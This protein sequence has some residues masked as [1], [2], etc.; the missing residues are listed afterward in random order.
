MVG[1]KEKPPQLNMFQIPL[2]QFISESHELVQLSRKIDWE[3]LEN[4]LS[5]YYCED[6]GRPC[7]PIRLI[8][9]VIMLRRIFNLSDES[10]FDRWVEN[11]YWQYFFGEIYFQHDFPFDRTDLI[12]FRRRIGEKGAEQILKASVNLVGKKEIQGKEV[13]IDTTVQEKNITFPTD[14]KLQKRI[15][16]KCL[17]IAREESIAL[18]QVYKWEL[19]QLMID[20]RF[21][22]HPR[23]KKKALTARRKIKVIAGKILRDLERKMGKVER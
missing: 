21:W 14:T 17:K 23:R 15:I 19:K 6:N 18:R 11:P 1:K 12:K 13:L 4:D 2:K 7:I 8:V 10:V 20:Q 5:V 9:G 3:D 22:N 16:E